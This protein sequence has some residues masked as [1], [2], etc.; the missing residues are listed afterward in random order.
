MS[1]IFNF[2][3]YLDIVT[4]VL[5]NT[6]NTSTPGAAPYGFQGARFCSTNPTSPPRMIDFPY[7]FGG[8]WIE[9]ENPLTANLGGLTVS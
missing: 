3:S 6:S 4:S 7:A 5:H 8:S 1:S 2:L 9:A